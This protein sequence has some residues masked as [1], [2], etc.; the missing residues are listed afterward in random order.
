MDIGKTKSKKRIG[1][2]ENS[3][4]R[5]GYNIRFLRQ[6]HGLSQQQ[7]ADILEI[8][9]NNIASFE[10]GLVEPRAE[11]FLNIACHFSV[12]PVDLLTR[13]LSKHPL[14][15]LP[16]PSAEGSPKASVQI[17]WLDK[18]IRKTTEGQ[19][20]LDGFREF[21]KLKY[22]RYPASDPETRSLRHDLDNLL[23]ILEKSLENNW[24]LIHHVQKGK[25]N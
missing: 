13:D 20:I 18:L 24:D 12:A 22:T 9:R 3:L 4:S 11:I 8:K 10:S 7:L 1:P 25:K 16:A 21:Y 15:Y 17:E 23:D 5:L 2:N 14:A 19:N 6:L